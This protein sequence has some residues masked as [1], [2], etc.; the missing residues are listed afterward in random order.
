MFNMDPG[1]QCYENNYSGSKCGVI[2]KHCLEFFYNFFA[3]NIFNN[4]ETE[5]MEK[6]E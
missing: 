4:P 1:F 2:Y 3:I 5:T 6:S